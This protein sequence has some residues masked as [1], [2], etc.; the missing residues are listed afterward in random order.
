MGITSVGIGSGLNVEDI[1]TKLVALEKA[2]LTTLAKQA[3]TITT[4]VSTFAQIKS[5]VST[6]ADAASKLTRDSGWNAMSVTSSKSEAVTAKVTGIAAAG[7]YSLEVSKLAQAQSSVTATAVP[8][9]AVFGA[10]NLSIQVGAAAA[11]DVKIESGDDTSLAGIAAKINDK[12]AGVVATVVSDSSGQRL[13]V[14]SSA[15]G[16]ANGFTITPTSADGS[17][18]TGLGSLSFATSQPAQD[19]EAK[20]NGMPIS[21]STREL[22][23]A[24]PGLTFTVAQKTPADTPVDLTVSADTASTKKNVQAFVDSY[25]AINDLLSSS[26]KYDGD[27][28]QGGALQGDSTAVTLQNMLRTAIGSPA[29]AGAFSTLSDVGIAV[30]RGGNL[31]LDAGKFDKALA[32]KPD[33]VKQLF[34]STAAISDGS[35]GIAVKLKAL[36]TSLLSFDGTLNA[37]TD[38]LAA[39]TKRNETEQDKVETRAAAVEKRLRA[40]YSAL[41]SRMASLTALNGYV[42]Q[43]ITN[44]NKNSG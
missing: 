7:S 13:M 16:A 6:F 40:Q 43:Q 22:S 28:K 18:A 33:D 1:V 29:A 41:D 42:S 30:Q 20:L 21:S 2:P 5:L 3:A 23:G 10:G 14:R 39:Q 37:K 27:T 35:K 44:W 4:K 31:L 12:K 26:V 15:T 9:T 38:A 36:T 19:T 17:A 25:N 11:V 24:V 8:A 32:D 34:A